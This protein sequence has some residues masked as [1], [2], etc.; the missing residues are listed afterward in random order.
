M[1]GNRAKLFPRQADA[2]ETAAAWAARLA[3]GPLDGSD[4]AALLDWLSADA[5]NR[6]HLEDYR[7]VYG[8]LAQI[9]PQMIRSGELQHAGRVISVSR[10]RFRTTAAGLMV[11]AAIAVA[12]VWWV[13][14]PQTLATEPGHRES[15]LLADGSHI[16]LNA[17]TFLDVHLGKAERRV[18]M[19]EGEAFF[20]V[21]AD[22][23]RPFVVRSGNRSITVLGTAFNVRAGAGDSLEVTVLEGAVSLS[24]D[25]SGK[26]TRLVAEE[27]VSVVGGA[28]TVRRLDESAAR[29]SAAWREGRVIFESARLDA[30]VD[31][32]ARYHG[33]TI[34]VEPAAAGLELGGRFK[35]D[36][37]DN[38]LRGIEISL[39][40]HVLRGSD[41]AIRIVRADGR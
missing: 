35:L 18:T 21:A 31:R 32:F 39:P 7:A 13:R 11:A 36:E 12:A 40:I 28:A 26:S 15:V 29:E 1:N 17:Q 22:S 2:H 3:E 16:D 38:F 9:V 4:Q 5:A 30:A 34:D 6:S 25:G 27:Q 37:L 23:S 10:R 19:R 24:E 33:V 20:S 8:N 41:G 14:R